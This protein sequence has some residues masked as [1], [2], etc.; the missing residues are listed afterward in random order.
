MRFPRIRHRLVPGIAAL[1]AAALAAAGCSGGSDSGGSSP[2]GLEKTTLNVGILPVADAAQL[3]LAIDRGFFRAEGLTVKIQMLQGGAEGPPKLQSGNLDISFGAYVPFFMAKEGGF[4]LHIV[5]DAFQSAPGT[6]TL[7]VARDSPIHTVRDLVGKKVGV[8]VK[9]NLSSLLVQATLQ[10][11]GVTLDDNKN[12]VAIPFPNMEAALKNQNVDA[13]QAVEP[14][15]S[16]MQKSIGARLITDLSQG[17][18]ADFPIAGYASTESWAKNNPNT[19]AAFSRAI[20]KAQNLLADRQILA[21]TLPTYTQIDAN[22]AATL[23]V[24]AFPASVNTTR[25]QR[26][27]DMARQYGYLRKPIDVKS[28]VSPG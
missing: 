22:T 23:H 5:A 9:R 14:F 11:Q 21:Q 26:V 6:H 13:V 2:S 27:V 18:T 10:P 17:P 25:L 8:N 28:L 16:Q 12:F 20:N 1:T 4:P 19:L 7:L 24:G 15:S 3:K